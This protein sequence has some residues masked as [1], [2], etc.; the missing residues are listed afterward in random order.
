[1]S[2]HLGI[3][4]EFL[5]KEINGVGYC[6]VEVPVELENDCLW[7]PKYADGVHKFTILEDEWKAR[8]VFVKHKDSVLYMFFLDSKRRSEM[9]FSKGTLTVTIKN[10][11]IRTVVFLPN[12]QDQKDIEAIEELF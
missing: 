10:G 7:Y 4:E 1:M 8:W 12:T 6:P 5:V 9:C 3:S 11:V 2:I